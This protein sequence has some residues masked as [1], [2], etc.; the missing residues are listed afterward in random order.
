[1]TDWPVL[2]LIMEGIPFLA[3][4]Y[5]LDHKKKMYLL[6]RGVVDRVGEEPLEVRLER[7]LSCGLFL[8]LAG[9]SLVFSPNLARFAGIE[10]FLSFELLVMG[11]VVLSSGLAMLLGYGIMRGRKVYSSEGMLEF[12]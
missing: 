7:R 6:E 9:A 12:K 1:M 3:F 5:Y 8:S 2:L 4:V 11:I 10:T